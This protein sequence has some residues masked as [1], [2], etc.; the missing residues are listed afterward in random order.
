[1]DSIRELGTLSIQHIGL[2]V[3]FATCSSVIVYFMTRLTSELRN[4]QLQIHLAQARQAH[5]EKLEALGTLAAGTA[6]EMATPLSTIAIVARDVE[7]AFVDHPPDFPGAEEVLEDLHLIRS[8]L[9]RCR[10]ILNRMAGQAGQTMGQSIESVTIEHLSNACLEG[11]IGQGRIQLMLPPNANSSQIHVPLDGLS[12]ALRGLIQNALDADPSDRP[13][14]IEV[15]KVDRWWQWKIRDRGVGMTAAELNRV[16]EPFFTTKPPGK[17]MGLGVFLA[18]NVIERLEGTLE[19]Q[20]VEGQ[21]TSVIVRL[22][23]KP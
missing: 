23:A 12:Q 5:A 22:P 18:K 17:G 19:F 10:T 11:L 8:Q 7:Q 1:L 2:I 4:N 13:V 21:G 14:R 3:A 16:S 9:E 6:H 15:E 20:S